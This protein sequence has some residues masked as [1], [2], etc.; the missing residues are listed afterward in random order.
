MMARHHSE[1]WS[2]DDP[3][4]ARVVSGAW[5]PYCLADAVSLLE[6]YSQRLARKS[7]DAQLTRAVR[8]L[9]LTVRYT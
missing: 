6:E 5:R 8:V 7:D 4:P 9:E 2:Y 3:T 1:E